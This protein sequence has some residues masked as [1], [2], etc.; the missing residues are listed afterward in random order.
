MTSID[1]K[2]NLGDTVYFIVKS[3]VGIFK[4]SV[5]KIYPNHS[6]NRYRVTLDDPI[7][8]LGKSHIDYMEE[9]A[10]LTTFQ[11]AKVDLLAWLHTKTEEITNL[12][13]S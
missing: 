13:E 2:F 10:L 8:Y 9:S 5:T 4:A 11:E 3:K 7:S 1:I 6:G 12:I